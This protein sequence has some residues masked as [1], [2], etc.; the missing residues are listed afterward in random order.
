MKISSLITFRTLQLTH[1][2]L[3]ALIHF[4]RRCRLVLCVREEWSYGEGYHWDSQPDQPNRS[5]RTSQ[6]CHGQSWRKGRT[7]T[8]WTS[9]LNSLLSSCCQLERE[10]GSSWDEGGQSRCMSQ[11][12]C[13]LEWRKRDVEGPSL[14]ALTCFSLDESKISARYCPVSVFEYHE[15]EICHIRLQFHYIHTSNWIP[16][17]PASTTRLAWELASNEWKRYTRWITQIMP[18]QRNW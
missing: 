9:I 5:E 6:R 7:W 11:K 4:V 15:Q 1:S 3:H 13:L 2:F 18:L 8:W 17:R 16:P 12:M 14:I 10:R